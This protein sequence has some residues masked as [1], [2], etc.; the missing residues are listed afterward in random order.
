MRRIRA[1]IVDDE[2][3]AR[4]GI[5]KLLEAD[6][7]ME[8]AGECSDGRL[9]LEAIRHDPPDIVLLDVQMPEMDGF[10][11]VRSVGPDRMPFVVFITAFDRYA[12]DAF[13]VHA[14]DYLLKPFTDDRFATAMRRAK[15]ALHNA[16]AGEMHQRLVDLLGQATG[17]GPVSAPSSGSDASFLRRLVV[18]GA[19]RVMFVG[20]DEIDWIEAADYYAKLHVGGK[21]HLIR[22]SLRSLEH[23]LDP[24]RF[25]RIHRS[26]I[27]NLDRVKEIQPYSSR[28][29]I[30]VLHDG[31]RLALSQ[32]RRS[33]L[34]ELLGQAL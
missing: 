14:L 19:G 32:R 26:V 7:E 3:H 31:S 5:R 29:S 2:P 15:D 30:I 12:L 20:V 22:Q 25:F 16:Q 4:A 33:S 17:G 9:A 11:V 23:R 10:D 21:T 34:A 8:V 13:E 28:S 6:P 1:L 24:R 18:R 27:V